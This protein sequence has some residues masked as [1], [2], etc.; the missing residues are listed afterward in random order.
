MNKWTK[1]AVVALVSAFVAESVNAQGAGRGGRGGGFGGR[2]GGFGGPN[3]IMAALDADQ[4]GT[5]SASEIANAAAALKK[6]DKNS[7]GKISGDEMRPQR[8]PG[9]ERGGRGGER[10]GRGGGFGGGPGGPG[11]GG[12]FADRLMEF[13]ENKDGKIT[14]SELPER[15]SRILDRADT[16]KD[17]ALS[18]DE[19]DAMARNFGGGGGFGGR[20]G[21]RGGRGGEGGGNRPQRPT[22]P[23]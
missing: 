10:G 18:K 23:Q 22:R 16:N 9:G 4:D 7:D 13:D 21:G 1:V 2:G 15:M 11:G 20:G 14:A 6:L 3:P 8:G 5:L 12:S 17:G 19:I